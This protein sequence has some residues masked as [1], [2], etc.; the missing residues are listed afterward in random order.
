MPAASKRP[1]QLSFD[2]GSAAD[3]GPGV[4]ED[5]EER[6][7]SPAQRAREKIVLYFATMK[8]SANELRRT[9]ESQHGGTATYVQ[10][11]PIH[12]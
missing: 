5:E 3:F 9:I 12:E 10:S 1:Q 6:R 2:Y 7:L 11:V 4:F 8:L